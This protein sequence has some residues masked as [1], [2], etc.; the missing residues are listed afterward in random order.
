MH[1]AGRVMLYSRI[2]LEIAKNAR[3][4]VCWPLTLVYNKLYESYLGVIRL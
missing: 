4:M 1:W 3:Q 2:K